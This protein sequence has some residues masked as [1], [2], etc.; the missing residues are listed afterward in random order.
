MYFMLVGRDGSRGAPRGDH[1]PLGLKLSILYMS[2]IL[3]LCVTQWKISLPLLNGIFRPPW[4]ETLDPSLLV[5]R[6]LNERALLF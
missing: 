1:P 3:Y 4:N 6:N 2:N 5:G